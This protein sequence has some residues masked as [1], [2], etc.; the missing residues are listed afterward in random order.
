VNDRP[1]AQELVAAVRQFLEAELLPTLTDPR[2]R[3]QTLVAANVLGIA[4]RELVTEEEQLRE[5]WQA[6]R[7]VFMSSGPEP[8]GLD[9]L[10]RAVRECNELLVERIREGTFDEPDCFRR[11]CRTLRPIVERKL[12]VANPRYLAATGTAGREKP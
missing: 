8:Q 11:G 7:G 6:L 4:E 1:T 2:L 10:R 9:A 12:R 5:E 3:F